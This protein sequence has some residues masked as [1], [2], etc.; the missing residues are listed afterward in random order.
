ME[1]AA[2]RR[3]QGW[4]SGFWVED[5]DEDEGRLGVGKDVGEGFG[6]ALGSSSRS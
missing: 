1:G 6:S 5:G 4:I 3:A 2:Q